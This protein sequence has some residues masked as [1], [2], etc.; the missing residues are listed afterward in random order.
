MESAA[1]PTIMDRSDRNA[2]VERQALQ[3]QA[4]LSEMGNGTARQAQA[5]FEAWI[6]V[7]WR[8][9]ILTVPGCGWHL[10]TAGAVARVPG[11]A[12]GEV[13]LAV[14]LIPQPGP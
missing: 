10:G 3:H 9:G 5:W 12:G 11:G 4:P 8:N 14:G 7:T 1:K 13:V 2:S 6:A